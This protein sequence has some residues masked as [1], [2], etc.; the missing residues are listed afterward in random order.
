L[1]PLQARVF[2]LRHNLTAYDGMHVALTEYGQFAS[3]QDTA[4]DALA[5]G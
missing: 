2:E 1:Q 3:A 4:A 5:C